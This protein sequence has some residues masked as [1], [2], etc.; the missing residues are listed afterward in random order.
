MRPGY[1]DIDWFYVWVALGLL[2]WGVAILKIWLGVTVLPEACRRC[3][4]L[5]EGLPADQK[6]CPECG[7]VLGEKDWSRRVTWKSGRMPFGPAIPCLLGA[8]FLGLAV[9]ATSPQL[10]WE[11]MRNE[12]YRVYRAETGP[13]VYVVLATSWVRPWCGLSIDGQIGMIGPLWPEVHRR[14]RV[15]NVEYTSMSE[16]SPAINRG[17]LYF[18]SDGSSATDD[19]VLEEEI[20][21]AMVLRTADQPKVPSAVVEKVVAHGLSIG[22]PARE[23]RELGTLKAEPVVLIDSTG[24]DAWLYAGARWPAVLL[25]LLPILLVA[26][27]MWFLMRWRFEREEQRVR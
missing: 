19:A 18:Q 3:G 17:G 24:T 15:V 8:I 1:F 22:D 23:A 12:H 16:S 11:G 10:L 14:P 6:A 27:G 25:L 13:N 21:T 20:R 26:R 5:L 4:Y 2:C 9:I 7:A